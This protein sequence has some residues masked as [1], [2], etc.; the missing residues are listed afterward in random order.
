MLNLV[1][2]ADK[3]Q[4]EWRKGWANVKEHAPS[5]SFF[6][7]ALAG[8]HLANW[9]AFLHMLGLATSRPIKSGQLVLD[10]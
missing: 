4:P 5:L 8:L 3:I 9:T 6:C 7:T 2:A 1:A 10:L